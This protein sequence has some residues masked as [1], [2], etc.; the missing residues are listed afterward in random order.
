MIGAEQIAEVGGKVQDQAEPCPGGEEPGQR[1][2]RCK[3]MSA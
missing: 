1:Q 2:E 3:D